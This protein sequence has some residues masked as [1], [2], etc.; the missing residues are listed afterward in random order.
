VFWLINKDG[1]D[2]HRTFEGHSYQVN[3]I[4]FSPNGELL[5][6]GS[7]DQ[8]VRIWRVE[9][10]ALLFTLEDHVG[11]VNSVT[12]SPDG[13]TIASGSQDGTVILWGLGP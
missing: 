1:G 6:S 5:V 10:S 11:G 2:P 12:F 8:N 9:D 3:S 4:A 13:S 7:R